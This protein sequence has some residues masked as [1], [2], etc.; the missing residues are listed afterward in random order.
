MATK[1]LLAVAIVAGAAVVVGGILAGPDKR[2]ASVLHFKV[3]SELVG[4]TLDEAGVIPAG[5][6]RRAKRPLLVFLHGRS[7]HPDDLLSDEFYAGLAQLGPRAPVVVALDG[8]DHS[9]WHDRRDGRWGSYVLQEAIPRAIEELHA[10]PRRV[11]IGGISMGGYGAFDVAAHAE[12]GRF[13]AVGGHSP[14]FWLSGGQTAPGAFDDAVDFERHSV[15]RYAQ[16]QP[17][18]FGSTPLWID[19]GDRDPFVPYDTVVVRELQAKG[20]R[21]T[22]RVWPGEHEG[23]YWNRHMARYLRFYADA[24]ARCR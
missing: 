2:G 10:D 12:P 3:K 6:S 1:A 22:S 24:L 11:A 17:R 19:R 15:Y 4:R 23:E 13:C 21:V 8:G 18:P 14:A 9:Y 5:V 7:G 16:S 20:A